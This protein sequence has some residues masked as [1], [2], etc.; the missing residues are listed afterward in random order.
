SEAGRSLLASSRLGI[1]K[2]ATG[3]LRL[4]VVLALVA[5]GQ[6]ALHLIPPRL[7]VGQ[8]SLAIAR[9]YLVQRKELSDFDFISTNRVWLGK[10]L[11]TLLTH[12]ELA[13]YN[14]E[15]INW[16]IDDE[17]YRKFVLSPQIDPI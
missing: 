4:E 1:A 2:W 3:L 13:N 9:R 11:R 8:R 16:K 7:H 17:L 5:L 14:R 10:R 6:P 15:L 12:V